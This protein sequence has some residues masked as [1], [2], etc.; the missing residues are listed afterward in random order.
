M[1]S[2]T[3]IKICTESKL[4]L[5]GEVKTV[6]FVNAS[7]DKIIFISISGKIKRK[8]KQLAFYMIRHNQALNGKSTIEN[9][10]LNFLISSM[11]IKVKNLN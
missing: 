6:H 3:I 8:S 2:K 10:F 5:Y 1:T 7:R 4:A 11:T 9:S